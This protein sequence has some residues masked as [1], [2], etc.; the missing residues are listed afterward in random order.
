MKHE[1]MP[2]ALRSRGAA[3]LNARARRTWRPARGEPI[4]AALWSSKCQFYACINI[5]HLT[6]SAISLPKLFWCNFMLLKALFGFVKRVWKLSD[7]LIWKCSIVSF[8]FL[9]FFGPTFRFE[10][11]PL[12]QRQ[13]TKSWKLFYKK[14]T[15]LLMF[16]RISHCQHEHVSVLMLAFT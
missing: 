8:L 1:R 2:T 12:S 10:L 9:G 13:E 6:W 5:F 11:F 7:G 14:L 16:W 4:T 3:Q 15:Y